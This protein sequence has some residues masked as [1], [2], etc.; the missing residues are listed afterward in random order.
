MELHNALL[1]ISRQTGQ[2]VTLQARPAAGQHSIDIGSSLL[3]SGSQSGSYVISPEAA[4]SM[5]PVVARVKMPSG[6][7]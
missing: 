5:L 7:I 3:H 1:C 6:E 2:N 4:I